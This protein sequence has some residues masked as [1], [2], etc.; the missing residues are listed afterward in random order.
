MGGAILSVL[1]QVVL[2]LVAI[3]KTDCAIGMAVRLNNP[4][5][6]LV[7]VPPVDT[8]V[9]PTD[10]T[11]NEYVSKSVAQTGVEFE[12]VGNPLTVRITG[13]LKALKQPVAVS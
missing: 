4:P 10:V 1:L 13:V 12:I 3:I 6:T 8:M 5:P 2:V 11:D 9:D 7:T